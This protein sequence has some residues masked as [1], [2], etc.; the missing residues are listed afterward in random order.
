MNNNDRRQDPLGNICR[1]LAEG[2][3]S[4]VYAGAAPARTVQAKLMRGLRAPRANGLHPCRP[5]RSYLDLAHVFI[6]SRMSQ[7]D[8]IN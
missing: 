3:R 5:S 6:A 4:V 2:G 7:S 8:I 1:L